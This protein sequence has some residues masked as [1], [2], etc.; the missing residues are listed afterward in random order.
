MAESPVK[1]ESKKTA[2]PKPGHSM[3][4]VTE[5]PKTMSTSELSD[6][7]GTGDVDVNAG[8]ATRSQAK[9]TVSPIRDQGVTTPLIQSWPAPPTN[10]VD[11]KGKAAMTSQ[12][13][14]VSLD[15][16]SEGSDRQGEPPRQSPGPDQSAKKDGG[17][18]ESNKDT[19]PKE[20]D[21]GEEEY[22]EDE[23]EDEDEDELLADVTERPVIMEGVRSTVDDLSTP[24]VPTSEASIMEIEDILGEKTNQ[25]ENPDPNW[26]TVTKG[27][28]Y[29]PAPEKSD[30]KSSGAMFFPQTFDDMST[31]NNNHEE[32]EPVETPPK[33][34]KDS[35]YS[36]PYVPPEPKPSF[37]TIYVPKEMHVEGKIRLN[38]DQWKRYLDVGYEKTYTAM[39]LMFEKFGTPAVDIVLGYGDGEDEMTE[40]LRGLIESG[41]LNSIIEAEVDPT[42]VEDPEPDEDV[43]NETPE[44]AVLLATVT[45]DDDSEDVGPPKKHRSKR[46]PKEGDHDVAV[47]KLAKIN[48]KT[49]KEATANRPMELV[50]REY[51]T[52]RMRP[53][54][55]AGSI[56]ASLANLEEKSKEKKRRDKEKKAEALARAKA[57]AEASKIA[58]R[59]STRVQT[60][61]TL[62]SSNHQYGNMGSS[63]V[64]SIRAVPLLAQKPAPPIQN[65][66]TG[67]NQN[68]GAPMPPNQQAPPPVPKRKSKKKKPSSSGSSSSSSSSSTSTSYTTSTSSSSSSPSS[69][70]G[71]KKH[72]KHRHKKKYRDENVKMKLPLPYDGKADLEAFDQWTFSVTNYAKVMRVSDKTMIRVMTDLVSGKAKG[73]YMDYVAMRQD[74]WTL[75]TLFPAIFDYCFPNDIM[76]RLRKRWNNMSQGKSRVED[77]ARDMEKLARKFKEVN[78]RSAVLAFW[79]GLNAE[80]RK[81]MVLLGA[82]PE[83]DDLN[84]VIDK[85]LISEKSLDQI[86]QISKESERRTG[87]ET[88]KP[89]REWTRFKNRNGGSKNF[90]P[91]TSDNKPQTPKSD[92]VRANAMSP[93]NTPESK[94]KAGPSYSKR[95]PRAKLDE[96][97]LGARASGNR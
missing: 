27:S 35:K 40:Y 49:R 84:S 62:P 45:T 19:S 15:R 61:F 87:G 18:P 3:Q 5:T 90:K 56:S 85:A 70:G 92:K 16:P 53:E 12:K 37:Y 39:T 73:F 60:A 97:T 58:P 38:L 47:N 52:N 9:E 76:E 80:L 64:R 77:Y 34:S 68:Q 4:L 6:T 11:K 59:M 63:F 31:I 96:L 89:K 94:P 1:G 81:H 86:E 54:G 88:S 74:R 82:D 20:G 50:H 22:G 30:E 78:E 48:A 41:A 69:S 10:P 36:R 32:E 95:L 17:R 24:D 91:G 75:A 67:S 42:P 23:E 55:I 57:E 25:I 8:R 72:R 44:T 26:N 79:K 29:K 43:H 83:I 7:W 65:V 2:P 33:R 71:R 66:A 21:G 13:S 28:N 14:D 93:Q 51:G 46:R